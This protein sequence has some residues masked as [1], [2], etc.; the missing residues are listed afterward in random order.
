MTG[1]LYALGRFAARHGWLVVGVWILL[2]VGLVAA[3]EIAGKQTSDDLTIPGSD[4]TRA[5]DLLDAKLPSRANGSVPVAMD[6]GKGSR[7]DRGS[8]K[9]AVDATIRAYRQDPRVRSV[10]SPF[11][12]EGADQ[13]T[14]DG[15]YGYINLSVREAPADLTEEEAEELVARADPL[16]RAGIDAAVGAYVGQKVSKPA[17]ESSEVIGL[18]VAMVVL[19]FAFGTLVAM[20]L[21]IVTA[22]LGLATGLSLIG[23][24]GHLIEIPSIAATLG[25]M[26]GLGVGIDYALFIVTRHFG[27]LAQ[28]LEVEE[29]VARATATSG[30]AVL[31]AGSTVVIALVSL[32]FGGIPIVSALGYSAAIVVAVAV[33]AALTLL[34]AILGLLGERIHN[35]RLPVRGHSDDHPHGWARWARGIGRRP[36]LAAI[37]GT[38]ILV[39]LAIPL[40]D[41]TLGQ[42]DNSQLPTDTETRQSYDI[43]E[44]GFGAGTNGPLLVSVKLDP[45]AKPN[46]KKL[47]RI[48]DKQKKQEQQAQQQYEEQ[49]Q[50]AELAGEPPPPEPAGPTKKQ[51]KQQEQQ[52]KFLKSTASDPRL[53]KLGNQISKDPDVDSASLP[54]VNSKGTAAVISVTSDSSPISDRTVDLVNRLRDETIP[55]ALGSGPTT[56]YVG[57]ST[58]SY[59]D[60]AD[61]IG[62]KLPLVIAIVVGLSFLLLMVAF[63]SIVVPLTA[64][65]M[66]LVSVAAAYGVLVA[67]F[68]EGVG[69]SQ[70]GLEREIPIVSLR[71][72]LDVRDP[73]RALDGLPGV[74]ADAD[75]GALQGGDRQPRLRRR[76]AGGH[77]AGDHLR[78]DDHGRR[79]RELHP[80]RRPDRQAVR[81]RPRGGGGDRRHDRS[82]RARSRGDDPVREGELVVPRVPRAP[83]AAARDR[84][85][86]VLRGARREGG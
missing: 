76:G 53:V 51:Q 45:P 50:Q 27:F 84:G 10:T 29:S 86:G 8:D 31:F 67:V 47:N 55:D 46:T 20:P 54:V 37:A 14:K 7:L 70:I 77:R 15:R 1:P 79:L 60:L 64:G 9:Q 32:L 62:E 33:C 61:R 81:R 24:L 28:G 59:I 85:R 48:E 30:G 58:A 22:I 42:P 80:Q 5:T 66:N 39:A 56:A 49:A 26:L 74:P 35:A 21:P 6:A 36:A 40:L 41:I 57:G 73:L 71:P 16:R 69:L 72:A 68:E 38:A 44:A 34:P 25:T 23:L 11:S 2:A 65:L 18:A 4:S 19:A 63:R 17:T 83:H 13:L 12:A 78:G 52:K 75:P 3:A 43:L 82:L